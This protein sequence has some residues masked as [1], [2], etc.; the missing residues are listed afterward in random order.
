MSVT[1]VTV[2]TPETA[3]VAREA[4]KTVCEALG[5]AHAEALVRILHAESEE[6]RTRRWSDVQKILAAQADL[7]AIELYLYNRQLEESKAKG[8]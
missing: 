6:E 8:S 5:I 1:Y 4:V 7:C 3:K 2:T